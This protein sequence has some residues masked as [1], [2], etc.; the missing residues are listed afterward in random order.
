MEQ[1]HLIRLQGPWQCLARPDASPPSS[2]EKAERIVVNCRNSSGLVELLGNSFAGQ[3]AVSRRFHRPTGLTK[4][5]QV[6]LLI[7]SDLKPHSVSLN[8]QL[9][10]ATAAVDIEILDRLQPTNQL[11]LT[12]ELTPEK[13]YQGLVDL[14]TATLEFK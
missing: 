13:T 7:Q 8:G 12:F 4:E 6:R 1:P 3:L 2:A 11:Q 14:F 5:S 10:E 9:L